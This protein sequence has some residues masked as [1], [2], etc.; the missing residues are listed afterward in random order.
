LMNA[1][2]SSTFSVG[3]SLSCVYVHPISRQS[4]NSMYSGG[5]FFE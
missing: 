1:S 5:T 2:V 4:V 3:C